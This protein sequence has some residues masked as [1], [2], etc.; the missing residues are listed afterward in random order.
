M[1]FVNADLIVRA[2]VALI[3]SVIYSRTGEVVGDIA[4][5]AILVRPL[6]LLTELAESRGDPKPASRAAPSAL[7]G[8]SP[9]SARRRWR[10]HR[11]SP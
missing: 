11:S 4:A 8:R 9:S 6:A 2:V 10:A 7:P 1:R 3:G 5:S